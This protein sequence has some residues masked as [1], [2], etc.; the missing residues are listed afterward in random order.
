M[1]LN[2]MKIKMIKAYKTLNF[3]KFILNRIKSIIQL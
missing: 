1:K 2:N 3:N